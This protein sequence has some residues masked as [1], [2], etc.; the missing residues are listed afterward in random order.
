MPKFE[1][2]IYLE[3]K[4]SEVG[5]GST[6][7][8]LTFR[9]FYAARQAGDRVE[10]F[11]LDDD[12]NLTGL[13]EWVAPDEMQGRFT[14]QPDHQERFEQLMDY[15]GGPVAEPRP[16]TPPPRERPKAGAP[17]VRPASPPPQTR[18]AAPPPADYQDKGWW[19]HTRKAAHDLVRHKQE[20]QD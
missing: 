7:S 10:L 13:R 15:V 14:H 16:E 2:G 1:P 9:N 6:A 3:T 8:T 17:Q 19:D 4:K 11:L 18:A 20:N 12:L 5:T